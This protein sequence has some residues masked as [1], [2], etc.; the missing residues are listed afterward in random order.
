MIR[1][2]Y[3]LLSSVRL[4]ISL[5]VVILLCCI[6]GVTVIRGDQA[7]RLI[8]NTLWFNG[9]LVLLVVNVA[10]CFFV[11][12]WRRR[13]SLI[14]FGM[15]LFHISFVGIFLGAVY[16]NLFYFKG[17]MRLSE[18]E[19][20]KNNDVESYDQIFH[21]RYFDLSRFRGE[22][23]LIKMHRG[24]KVNGKDKRIAYEIEVGEGV[25]KKRD[26]IYVTHSLEY[27]G[28][29]FFN[30]R[31]GYTVLVILYDRSGRKLYGAF[32]PLQSLRQDNDKFLYITGTKHGPGTLSF[33]YK[34]ERPLFSLQVLYI[35]SQAEERKGDAVFRLFPFND[36]RQ[37]DDK[38]LAEARAPIGRQVFT[39]GYFLEAREIRYWVGMEVRYDPGKPIVLTSLWMG[40]AGIVM[41]FIGRII[42]RA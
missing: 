31:E 29:K 17:M 32:I 33:P 4:A 15:I 34:P 2:I 7:W 12:I 36:K 6:T 37:V 5:L 20:L 38:P 23:T 42:K 9:L 26:I 3:G 24:Y 39:G 19:T 25:L 40:F 10:S 11:K 8:F 16:N 27:K 13:L 28:F 35:P 14:S 1:G 18:G 21:G 30:D 41:T 22:T